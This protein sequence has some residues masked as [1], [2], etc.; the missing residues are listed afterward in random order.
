MK[1]LY[2]SLWGFGL[3]VTLVSCASSKDMERLRGQLNSYQ[4]NS[5]TEIRNLQA[6][7]HKMQDQLQGLEVKTSMAQQSIDDM[8][9][10]LVQA[11]TEQGTASDSQTARIQA[12][13]HALAQGYQ[14]EV[15]T[16]RRNLQRLEQ[17]AKGFE[18]LS[19]A[20][21][22]NP[23]EGQPFSPTLSSEPR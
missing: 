4:S 15:E 13:I 10:Q 6:N 23:P 22:A 2:G 19:P 16:Y 8:R 21:T 12:L 20:M 11:E 1:R 3:L 5:T 7:L 18:Q 17:A 9:G 14:A